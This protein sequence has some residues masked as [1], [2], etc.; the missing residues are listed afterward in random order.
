MKCCG[1]ILEDK[2]TELGT[3][4]VSRFAGASDGK[5]ESKMTSNF[6]ENNL[7]DGGVIN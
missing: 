7:M 4:L 3:G 5:R 6:G 1:Y 2:P